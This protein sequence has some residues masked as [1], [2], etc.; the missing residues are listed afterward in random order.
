MGLE[1]L[2]NGGGVS[3]S[4]FFYGEK[5]YRANIYKF[6]VLTNAMNINKI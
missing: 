1:Y 5:V 2:G 4:K 3:E 6:K